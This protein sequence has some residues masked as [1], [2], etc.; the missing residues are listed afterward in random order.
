MVAGSKPCARSAC[1][2]FG[3]AAEAVF[4]RGAGLV[5]VA[6]AGH[7]PCSRDEHT[8]CDRDRRA[9][10]DAGDREDSDPNLGD[11]SSGADVVLGAPFSARDAGGGVVGVGGRADHSEC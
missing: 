4:H 11:A 2:E 6:Q 9:H 8:R 5:E 3:A 1:T 7:R 10:G